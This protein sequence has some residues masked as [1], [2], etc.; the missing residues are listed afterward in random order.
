MTAALLGLLAQSWP[1]F[2]LALVVL[3]A[4]NLNLREI[5]LGR[6]PHGPATQNPRRGEKT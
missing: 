4:S 6:R 5:R 2:F 1:L 3:L